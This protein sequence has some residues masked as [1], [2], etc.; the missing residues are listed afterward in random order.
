MRRNLL[1]HIGYQSLGLD[2]LEHGLSAERATETVQEDQIVGLG[3][4]W[5]RTSFQLC[6][7]CISGHLPHRHKPFLVALAYDPYK[8]LVEVKA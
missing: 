2:H 5:L 8:A 4:I 7:H 1:P 6:I 3:V